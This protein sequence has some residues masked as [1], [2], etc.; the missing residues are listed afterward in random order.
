VPLSQIVLI[1]V[2][3]FSIFLTVLYLSSKRQISAA[4]TSVW[5]LL[6]SSLLFVVMNNAF[7]RTLGDFFQINSS[8]VIIGMVLFTQIMFTFYLL[9]K[10]NK[11]QLVQK[12]IVQALSLANP[13]SGPSF[14][15]TLDT[16]TRKGANP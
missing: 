3:A 14:F 16:R 11:I 6:V 4:L 10:I 7:L 8:S 13:I 1:V 9:V 12:N 2:F 15:K 5:F